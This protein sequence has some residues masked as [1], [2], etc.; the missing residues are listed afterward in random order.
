MRLACLLF[1]QGLQELRKRAQVPP[2]C[3]VQILSVVAPPLV[4][5]R[6]KLEALQPSAQALLASP[7]V[8]RSI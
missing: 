4:Q 7:V 5:V 8:Q 2:R 1:W 3:L 6:L